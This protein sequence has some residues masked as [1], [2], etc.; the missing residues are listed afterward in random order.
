[1]VPKEEVI[2]L[3]MT[4]EEAVRFIISAGVVQPQGEKCAGFLPNT[5]HNNNQ[6]KT[7]NLLV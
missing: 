6:E 5:G 4:I 3:D 7:E 2:D 1:V